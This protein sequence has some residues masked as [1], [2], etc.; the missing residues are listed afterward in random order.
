[1]RREKNG[2]NRLAVVFVAGIIIC[3]LNMPGWAQYGGGSGTEGDPFLISEP[4][5]MQA[6]GVHQE[7]WVAGTFFKLVE[8]IDL[9]Q[10]TGTQFNII[11]YYN[12]SFDKEFF[13]GI[14]DGNDH[15]ILNFTY[16]TTSAEKYVGLFGYFGSTGQ[17]EDLGLEDPNIATAGDYVGSLV[18]Y[19]EEG[20]VSNC[21]ATGLVSGDDYLGGLVGYNVLGTISNCFAT[22]TVIGDE[23]SDYLGG[24]VGYNWDGT[25]SDCYAI[26][27]VNGDD[28]LGGLVGSNLDGTISN[29]YATGSVSGDDYL[30]G[31][32]GPNK[33]GAISN[34]YATGTISGD[35]Y[36]GGL[37]GVNR[38]G[39]I[40]NCYWDENSSGLSYSHGGRKKTTAQMKEEQTYVG[41]ND[42]SWVIDAGIDYP[43]LAWEEDAS[44]L[45]EITTDY[46]ARTYPGNG[47]DQ[48]F[49]L[50]SSED[51]ICLS[52]RTIDWDKNFILTGDID[53]NMI[54]DYYSPSGFNG[55]L[56]GAGYSVINLTVDAHVIGN[57]CQLGLIGQLGNG[58]HIE[59]LGVEEVNIIGVDYS[60]YLGGLVG[61]NEEGVISNCYATGAVTGGA[62]AENLGGLV[63]YTYYGAISNCYAISSVSGNDWLGGL[64][65]FNDSGTIYQ[66]YTN[67]QVNGGNY[68][69]GLVGYTY[70]GTISDSNAI[71]SVSGIDWLGGLV[72]YNEEGTI[73]NC[74]A[75]GTVTGGDFSDYLGG[76][77]GVNWESTISNCYANGAVTGGDYSWNLGGLVGYNLDGTISNCNATGAVTGGADSEN[78][79]GL[80]GYIRYGAISNCYAT[81]VVTG[82]DY[83]YYLG[84]LVGYNWDGTISDCYATGSVNGSDYSENLGG[85]L[86]YDNS[87]SYTKSFWDETVNSGLS[88]I[89]NTSDPNV[90]AESTDNLYKASTFTSVGW[91]F[92]GSGDNEPNDYWR[93]CV[94]EV[95]YPKLSWQFPQ[96]DL[97]CPDGVD[98]LDLAY[99]VSHWLDIDCDPSNNYCRRSD[100]N[101]SGR[102]DLGDYALLAV[103]WLKIN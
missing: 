67:S 53:M 32:V 14:F 82:G 17:I 61:Y 10:Y 64:C 43:H 98:L 72:G 40:S 87:G 96:G 8:D 44:G 86:G 26:G 31:L 19:N 100:L 51:L 78:L 28:Y 37:V 52:R 97:V 56:D 55:Y 33:Y 6:I 36:L 41:W 13:S 79:G 22:G 63:G 2:N 15:K 25:I 5:H 66:C 88:G 99:F 30:G 69:G 24:L 1:M 68:L 4:N 74:F 71:G 93:L 92:V 11:G 7:H 48:S 76:L 62:N 57:N 18:G 81:G 58:G 95:E 35:G 60:Y 73:S 21:Y 47:E 85:L 20:T 59:N 16:S 50:D 91:D 77:A 49:E 42:G 80:V 94:D 27:S 39:T 83:S 23:Y 54:T 65:G 3:L 101:Y 38:Y 45:P 90:I 12:S 34:C 9:S 103:H 75:T 89:G 70:N 84:G 102:V 46:P 29:C